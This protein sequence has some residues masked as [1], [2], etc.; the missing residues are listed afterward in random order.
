MTRNRKAPVRRLKIAAFSARLALVSLVDR[1][2][3][4]RSRDQDVLQYVLR[5]A[6]GGDAG[7]VL[8]AMDTFATRK[9]WLMNIGPIKGEILLAA[10][11]RAAAVSVL[12]IGAYCGYSATLIGNY[13]RACNGRLISIEKNPRYAEVA[14]QVT[15]HAGLEDIVEIRTGTLESL[16]D[17]LEGPFDGV[18][19]DHWKEEYLPDLKRLEAAGLL[20]NGCVVVADNVGLFHLPEYLDHV[21]NSGAYVSENREASVEY[22]QHLADAVEV[23]VY[24]QP[25]G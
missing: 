21:R 3:L 5:R 16:L 6:P 18:L 13:L 19:L 1:R 23:S 2:V 17:T 9:R 14:R 11:Q 15:R 12:E 22:R 24:T 7:A 4:R 20:R 8:A 25:A 10:L